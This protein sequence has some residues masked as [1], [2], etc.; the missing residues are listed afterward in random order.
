M[1]GRHLPASAQNLGG[2]SQGFPLATSKPVLSTHRRWG[3]SIPA[4][5]G[6]ATLFISI[7]FINPV[8]KKQVGTRERCQPTRGA[9]GT[10]GAHRASEQDHVGATTQD[11]IPLS[12]IIQILLHAP[13][14]LLAVP[15]RQLGTLPGLERSE[16]AAHPTPQRIYGTRSPLGRHM[17]GIP[18]LQSTP[19][20]CSTPRE[21]VA[22]QPRPPRCLAPRPQS[23]DISVLHQDGKQQP[24]KKNKRNPPGRSLPAS[25]ALKI[26]SWSK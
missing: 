15:R 13:K 5:D 2:S 7:I 18:L 19:R 16:S 14:L 1:L 12:C 8:R 22:P 10:R 4:G 9:G 11:E 23:R 20:R 24:K 25:P 6:F 21:E 3:R 17:G 26:S